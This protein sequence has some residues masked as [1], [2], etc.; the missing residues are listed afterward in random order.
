MSEWLYEIL[1]GGTLVDNQKYYVSE[2]VLNRRNSNKTIYLKEKK[3][4]EWSKVFN[5]NEKVW[6]FLIRLDGKFSTEEPNTATLINSKEYEHN[7]ND[8]L[9]YVRG[10]R[11]DNFQLDT[12]NL[13]GEIKEG[14]YGLKISSRFGDSFLKYIISDAEGF[15]EIKDSGGVN[16]EGE[17]NWLL[18]YLWKIKLKRAF[19]L[20]IPKVYQSKTTISTK[21]K[22]RIDPVFYFLNE[23]TGKY[24]TT[25]REHCYQSNAAILIREV[26]KVSEVKTFLADIHDIQRAFTVASQGTKLNRSELMGVEHFSNPFYSE[27]NQVIDLSKKILFNHSMAFGGSE[28]TSAF[29]FDVSMLFEYFI[30]KLLLRSGFSLRS[31]FSNPLKIPTGGR[32]RELRPD[33]L[34]ETQG[35]LCVFDVKYK[36]FNHKEGVKREDLFQLHTYIGQYGNSN[37]IEC[38]GLIYPK[39]G[40]ENEFIEKEIMVMGKP[41][42]FIVCLLAVPTEEE[43]F[44]EKFLSICEKFTESLHLEI[45]LIVK[46][47]ELMPIT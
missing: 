14:D 9:V 38:C 21:V 22:G 5:N 45:N 8:H 29:L 30:K 26:M 24:R 25:Y 41:L 17:I 7:T 31:K 28:S 32:P 40:L 34:I 4:R 39:H 33:I 23:D 1:K 18:I 43:N 12:T 35:N 2:G 13:V 10:S 36:T 6:D 46:K 16:Y 19:R 20:G 47:K 37:K 27:Y 3:H 44:N 11:W 15:L 42:R